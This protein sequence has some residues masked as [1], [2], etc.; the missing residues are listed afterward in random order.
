MSNMNA[1]NENRNLTHA[2]ISPKE[3][4]E[5]GLI[6]FG[7]VSVMTY[8]FL[9]V[10]FGS[11]YSFFIKSQIGGGVLLLI[12]EIP[13][14]SDFLRN[15]LVGGASKLSMDLWVIDHNQGYIIKSIKAV[16]AMVSIGFG[17]FVGYLAHLPQKEK[18]WVSGNQIF[19][20]SKAIRYAA[21]KL[22]LNK[23]NSGV[24][25]G[26]IQYTF[27][28][29]TKHTIIVGKTGAGKTTVF[30]PMIL[31]AI[32]RGDKV[33][34]HDSKGG[35]FV[36]RFYN[37]DNSILLGV[38]DDRAAV[39]DIQKDIRNED[40]ARE[41]SK[42]VAAAS[43][44]ESN[45]FFIQSAQN[46]IAGILIYLM[47]NQKVWGWK[48]IKL[49]FE[50]TGQELRDKLITVL[51]NINRSMPL[52]KGQLQKSV[53]DVLS[54]LDNAGFDLISILARAE[55]EL[56]KRFTINGLLA[57][58]SKYKVIILNGH[59]SY[60]N[61]QMKIFN[62]II[63]NMNR[64]ITSPL[65]KERK[66]DAKGGFWLFLDEFPQLGKMEQ[67]KVFLEVGRSKGIRLVIGLQ[68]FSQ[69]QETYGDATSKTIIGLPQT[70]IFGS[71]STDSALE[72]SK[73]VGQ[74]DYKIWSASGYSMPQKTDV[75]D[76]YKIEQLEQD[77]SGVELY[78]TFLSDLY[79]TKV[80]HTTFNNKSETF[81]QAK[82]IKD[83]VYKEKEIDLSNKFKP[84]G[85]K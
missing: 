5:D 69:M 20:G 47:H 82:W 48:D 78:I 54:S 21:H 83:I 10:L 80:K 1:Q 8:L 67:I 70:Y 12:P 30:N 45:P 42:I 33:L 23:E 53:N 84:F 60:K 74:A 44:S 2:I 15:S 66:A 71:V 41:V 72:I 61:I 6:A 64:I 68:S 73:M 3:K 24:K 58:K 76:A 59:G 37:P 39:W 75:I 7:F 13:L 18:I 32:E 52:D 36:S 19:E 63:E 17:G 22:K 62:L 9:L 55:E 49:M 31:Q 51:P 11:I 34:I 4:W 35:D 43:G 27:D 29:E 56:T 65:Y 57:E 79:K 50:L 25:V 26:S 14:I 40:A 46:I 16:I 28:R 85:Q 38:W 81:I 77:K